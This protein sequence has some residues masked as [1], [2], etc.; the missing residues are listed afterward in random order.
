LLRRQW[1]IDRCGS[2]ELQAA[3]RLDE[4]GR[5]LDTFFA[6]KK[7]GANWVPLRVSDYDKVRRV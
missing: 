1:D 7:R 2:A 4:Q 3:T 6:G 5:G